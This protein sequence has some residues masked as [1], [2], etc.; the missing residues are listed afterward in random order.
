MV[1]IVFVCV[2]VLILLGVCVHWTTTL[3]VHILTK[4]GALWV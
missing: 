2:C 3:V 1:V 4:V